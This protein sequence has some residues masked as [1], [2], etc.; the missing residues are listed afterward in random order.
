MKCQTEHIFILQI[1]T[2][3]EFLLLFLSFLALP[4]FALTLFLAQKFSLLFEL[5][6]EARN[7]KTM[8]IIE[9]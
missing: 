6:P 5:S 1:E 8:G 4:L 3:L 7:E 9:G 2:N